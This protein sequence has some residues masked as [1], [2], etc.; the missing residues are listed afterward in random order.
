MLKRKLQQLSFLTTILGGALL[1]IAA[2]PGTA[3]RAQVNPCPSIYYEEPYNRAIAVPQGCPPNAASQLAPQAA[4]P[5]TQPG[6][7]PGQ[8]AQP[9]MQQRP[10]AQGMQPGQMAQPGMQQG[11]MAQGMQ[12]GQMAQPGMQQAQIPF[13]GNDVIAR[14]QPTDGTVNIRL[15]NST[16]ANITYEAIGHTQPRTL[17]GRTDTVLENLPAPV[18]LTMLRQDNGLI[19]ITPIRNVETGVLEVSV[20]EAP[21]FDDTQGTLEIQQDGRVVVN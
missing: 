13:R 1:A 3:A 16:N 9:G 21:S 17:P 12:P 20:R 15:V 2:I 19:D 6:M 14:V 11:Q 7:Q 8:M 5:L 4:R 18:T 10:M